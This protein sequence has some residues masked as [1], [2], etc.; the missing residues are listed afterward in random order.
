M[1]GGSVRY[2]TIV[3]HILTDV[4]HISSDL[5]NVYKKKSK[6]ERGEEGGRKV[7]GL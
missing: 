4:T 5:I 6:R 7:G 1:A 2:C 3:Y